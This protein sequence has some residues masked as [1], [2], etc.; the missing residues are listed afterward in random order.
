ML[1][2]Q[3]PLAKLSGSAHGGSYI[4]AHLLHEMGKRDK[5]QGLSSIVSLFRNR[6]NKF[7]NIG[8][9][10]LDS[11]YHRTLQLF[12]IHIFVMKTLRFCHLLHKVIR[13][14]ITV[15]KPCIKNST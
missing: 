6:F 12:K 8:A 5:M 14:V 1:R 15:Q 7:N 3:P 13:V 2:V 11:I 4:S 10:M 9:R